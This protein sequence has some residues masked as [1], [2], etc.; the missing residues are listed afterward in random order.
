MERELKVLNVAKD[1]EVGGCGLGL[2]AEQV[3]SPTL[4]VDPV[5]VATWV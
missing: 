2:I 3:M 1:T 4:K 5:L